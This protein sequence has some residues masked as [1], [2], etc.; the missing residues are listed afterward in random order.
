MKVFLH[1]Y[2]LGL[3]I[4]QVGM[5]KVGERERDI[6]IDGGIDGERRGEMDGGEV[7]KALHL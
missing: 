4:V 1:I 3:L 2:N 5:W 6:D 7:L